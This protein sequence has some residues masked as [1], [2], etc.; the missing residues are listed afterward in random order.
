MKRV[1]KLSK[2]WVL[3]PLMS[4][5]LAGCGGGGGSSGAQASA[6]GVVAGSKAVLSWNAPSTR[7]NG[8][9]LK[10]GELDKYVI[11]YGQDAGNLNRSVVVDNAAEDPTPSYTIDQ[12]SNGTWYFTIQVQDV[13]GLLSAPS[14]VVS[15]SITS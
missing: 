4:L 13:N 2:L 7:V 14:E 11:R 15:K 10:M 6:S 12:L 1:T 8:E 3:V 9:G 5:A